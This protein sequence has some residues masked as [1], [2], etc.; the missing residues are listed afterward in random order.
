[1]TESVGMNVDTKNLHLITVMYKEKGFNP[2]GN[3]RYRV[4]YKPD[5]EAPLEGKVEICIE[6]HQGVK[7]NDYVFTGSI[8]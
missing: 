2:S 1:M 4:K 3:D 7:E 5:G 6:C 8:K